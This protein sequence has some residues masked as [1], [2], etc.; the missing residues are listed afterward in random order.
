MRQ[1]VGPPS[2]RGA[3]GV[4]LL[5]SVFQLVGKKKSANSGGKRECNA[6]EMDM[7]MQ[8]VDNDLVTK[9]QP[10][11]NNM[12]KIIQYHVKRPALAMQ[13]HAYVVTYVR[14]GAQISFLPNK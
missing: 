2:S 5:R 13:K 11:D 3:R 10:A 14:R 7:G 12:E 1:S 8:V 4:G 9:I 6:W